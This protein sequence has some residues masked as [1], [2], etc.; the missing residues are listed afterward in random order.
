M[1][2]KYTRLKLK[3]LLL[4]AAGTAAGLSLGYLVLEYLVDGLFQAPFAQAFVWLATHLFGYDDSAALDLY[5]QYIR[6]NKAAFL[7][8]AILVLMLVAFYLAMGLFTRWLRQIS[9]G[10]RQLIDGSRQPVSLPRELSPGR[11]EHPVRH[12]ERPGGGDQAERATE[13]RPAGL[14]GPRPENTTHLC[15]RLPHPA[16]GRP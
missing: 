2:K 13:K 16:A 5:D 9:A 7:N 10:V 4:M 15:D 14:P 12:P 8:G 11:S 6:G 3:M 1:D